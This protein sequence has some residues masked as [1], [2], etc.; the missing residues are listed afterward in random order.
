MLFKG[1]IPAL[2]TPFRNGKV[3]ETAF[4]ALV[5]RQI[6]AGSHGVVVCG[7]TG[8]AVM[9]LPRSQEKSRLAAGEPGAS[10]RWEA[11]AIPCGRGEQMELIT[12]RTCGSRR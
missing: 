12:C 2:V 1:S 5:E 6:A 11:G 8:E 9:V 3:D 7:T 10:L 4:V